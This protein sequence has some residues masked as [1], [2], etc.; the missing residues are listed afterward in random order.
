[1]GFPSFRDE[2]GIG[3]GLR[4]KHHYI[5]VLVERRDFVSLK[6][7]V[8]ELASRR[9]KNRMSIFCLCWRV[10]RIPSR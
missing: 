7:R 3:R 4:G 10:I 5:R 1:M 2:E 9:G 6:Y 8:S